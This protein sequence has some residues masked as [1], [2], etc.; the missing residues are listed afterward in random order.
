MSWD[1]AT[2]IAAI[3]GKLE[4]R[5]VSGPDLAQHLKYH[6]AVLA[7]LEKAHAVEYPTASFI[8]MGGSGT[9]VKLSSDPTADGS[10]AKCIK[11]PQPMVGQALPF[12]LAE[13]LDKEAEA[14]SALHHE[15]I[16]PVDAIGRMTLTSSDIA[17]RDRVV[18]YYVMPFVTSLELPQFLRSEHA[19]A[20]K[21]ASLLH[22]IAAA[23]AYM[24]R[25]GYVHLDVKPENIFVQDYSGARPSALLADFGFCKRISPVSDQLTMVMVTDGYV[26]PE[27]EQ[28]MRNKTDTDKNRIRDRVSRRALSPR[29]D[30]FAFGV[31][32]INALVTYLRAS[33]T[34]RTN[35]MATGAFRALQIIALRCSDGY[36]QKLTSDEDQRKVAP[37]SLFQTSVAGA[38]KYSDT[39]E[40][41]RNMSSVASEFREYPM[42]DEVAD[43]DSTIICL[44]PR[45][46]AQLSPRV[47]TTL[48][49]TLMRRLANVAQLALCYHVYPGAAHTRKEHM[50]GTY[51]NA[52]SLLRHLLF[53]KDN[54]ACALLLDDRHQRLVLLGALLHDFGHIPLLHE[55]EDALPDLRQEIYMRETIDGRW[56]DS[57]VQKEIDGICDAWH[58]D[59]DDLRAI[60]GSEVK[61]PEWQKR[62]ATVQMEFVRSVLDGAIDVD[63]IDYLQRDALHA[64]V[65][66]GHGVDVERLERRATSAMS[67]GLDP[68]TPV[69]FR[70][71]AWKNAQAAAEA[72]ISARHNM[73]AQV[74]A[75]R[76]VRAARVMLN[77]VAWCWAEA[78]I[79]AGLS[80][81]ATVDQLYA[82]ASLLAGPNDQLPLRPHKE[83][84]EP[85]L[86]ARDNLPYAE[87]RVI[88]WMAAVSEDEA[89]QNLAEGL[90]ERSLYKEVLVLDESRVGA[91]LDRAYPASGRGAVRFREKCAFGP[92]DWIRL[93]QAL[94]A[95]IRTFLSDRAGS[96]SSP[97]PTAGT[98][99]EVLVDV[100]I[101]KTMR[102]QREL[103]IVTDR[104]GD[105]VSWRRI[106]QMQAGQPA[107]M[108]GLEV[109]TS[110][111]YEFF[112][113]RGATDVASGIVVRLFARPDLADALR[114]H[115]DPTQVASWLTAFDPNENRPDTSWETGAK[116]RGKKLKR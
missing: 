71:A 40:L 20:P 88:R 113:G 19:S 65:Q 41:L 47:K 97:P 25:A 89:A 30:R 63:K 96:L 77:Y 64:G 35:S 43:V 98:I 7:D 67:Q 56:G 37:E 103:V 34:G 110:P 84:P 59:R 1:S 80:S 61:D 105:D 55:L 68:A 106:E 60:F 28:L 95:M 76:T 24:H 33:V 27:L 94:G 22:D 18:P 66:Y 5:H 75:H 57:S 45:T 101:P 21:L 42:E 4:S 23:L 17:E 26:H 81:K 10:V 11:Y 50:L 31:T 93:T 78:P 58:V 115:L 100:A 38:L 104:L 16:I 109:V 86:R 6:A 8:G 62:Y 70:L 92:D 102:T 13:V 2:I 91:F 51:E 3:R 87:S 46:F 112:G 73:H 107:G 12:S 116:T 111:I 52:A 114:T 14:L 83:V 49:S 99:P 29:F 79:Y 82:Y 44:P 69:R 85:R 39:D 74:Y 72:V 108:F 48:D 15:H 36:A 90:I 54:P 53:D 32:I 9:A